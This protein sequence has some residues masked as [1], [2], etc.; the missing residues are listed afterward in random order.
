M[1]WKALNFL[2]TLLL[3]LLLLLLSCFLSDHNKWQYYVTICKHTL[4]LDGQC[5]E[6]PTSLVI[7][8][9]YTAKT[10]RHCR[11]TCLTLVSLYLCMLPLF[12]KDC[13][14]SKKHMCS[15]AHSGK[16]QHLCPNQLQWGSCILQEHCAG[17]I[18]W[19]YIHN[20]EG[21]HVWIKANAITSKLFT[22]KTISFKPTL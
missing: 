21:I 22:L 19:V 11:S 16:L 13:Q 20:L 10:S 15:A 18:L 8:H 17:S 9:F 2:A 14:A 4:V 6:R 1:S 3:L 5:H 12:C 7:T